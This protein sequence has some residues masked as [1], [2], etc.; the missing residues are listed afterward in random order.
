MIPLH[1]L[2][3]SPPTFSQCFF[4]VVI[5]PLMKPQRIG[6]DA[7]LTY[8]RQGGI[9]NY[10][11]QLIAHLPLVDSKN[12]YTIFHSR[13]DKR[14][15]AIGGSQTRRICWTPSHHRLERYVLSVEL[16]PHQLDLFHSPDFIPPAVGY[17]HSVITI[18]DL[19]FM[20]YPQ[21]LTN[22]SRRYYNDQI[23]YAVQRAEHIMTDSEATR[24]DV[25]NV[26]DV[27]PEK[28]TTV[29]LGISDHFQPASV[30]AIKRFQAAYDLPADYILFVGTFEPRKNI[31]GLLNAY[32]Q[33]IDRHPDTPPLMLAGR[34]GWLFDEIYAHVEVLNLTDRVLWRENIAYADL[35]ALYTAAS[36]LCLPSHYEGFGFPP[37]E[38]MAC[39][40]PVVIANRASLPEIVGTA[41][42]HI[43]PDDP[44]SLADGLHQTLTDSNLRKWL[45]E[46]GF[47]RVKL[48]DWAKTAEQV[49]SVYRQVLTS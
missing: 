43:D 31:T 9:A 13:K 36:V 28:V 41:G 21:F 2:T 44:E 20:H 45:I 23:N 24:M 1:L 32:T 11:E 37:L 40:T 22:D 19:T 47:E 7:R 42:I 16:L 3:A 38:A 30:E 15:L 10:I 18:H 35:P 4:M 26:L 29:W 39:G 6:I 33:L 46:A 27:P 17:R 25:L 8:Y 5:L 14:N 34:R 48:F 49:F 12:D